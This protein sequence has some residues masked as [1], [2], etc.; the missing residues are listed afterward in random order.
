M[1]G[2]EILHTERKDNRFWTYRG[3]SAGELP[4]TP[5]HNLLKWIVE[6]LNFGNFEIERDSRGDSVSVTIG[7]AAAQKPGSFDEA[8]DR[9]KRRLAAVNLAGIMARCRESGIKPAH[10]HISKMV[11]QQST[12]WV[13][14]N[15]EFHYAFE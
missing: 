4:E 2:T 12:D 10:A 14:R 7:K 9:V 13:R 5:L 1:S 15:T 6:Q 11:T 8:E 3:R